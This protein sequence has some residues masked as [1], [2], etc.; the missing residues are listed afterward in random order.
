M[1]L[2]RT[3]AHVRQ[4]TLRDKIT[5]SEAT[6][7]PSVR[8]PIHSKGTVGKV[9]HSH[10]QEIDIW[11]LI[12]I[13][14]KTIVVHRKRGVSSVQDQCLFHFFL[15]VVVIYRTEQGW[16]AEALSG[17]K[18]DSG[19][20]LGLCKIYQYDNL[21]YLDIRACAN[22]SCSS[23]RARYHLDLDTSDPCEYLGLVQ[24]NPWI[25]LLELLRYLT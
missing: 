9:C 10:C 20:N 15:A 4:T 7:S 23:S 21:F 6:S 16:P 11:I 12:G 8:H 1:N 19:E 3:I 25:S 22:F 2:R 24:W 17:S 18:V 13:S 5:Q 14:Q